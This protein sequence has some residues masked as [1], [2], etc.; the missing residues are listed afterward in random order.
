MSVSSVWLFQFR[1]T[2]SNLE[3]MRV[4]FYPTP[5]DTARLNKLKFKTL[6]SLWFIYL[7]DELWRSKNVISNLLYRKSDRQKSEWLLFN[8]NWA[9]FQRYNGNFDEMIMMSILYYTNT[10]S[11][12]LI[13]LFPLLVDMSLHFDI[14]FWF[15]AKQVFALTP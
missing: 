13:V 14:S 10:M 6:Q 2:T 5:L 7:D 8:T 11:L 4:F 9:I 12:I 15:W 3:I 1:Y